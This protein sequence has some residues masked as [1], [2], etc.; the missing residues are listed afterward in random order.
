MKYF[1]S[2]AIALLLAVTHIAAQDKAS[3]WPQF[4][5]PTGQGISKDKGV[6]LKWGPKE[7]I[8]W[9]TELPGAGASSPIVFGQRIYLTAF[10]GKA[11]SIELHVLA[12]N[13]AD[14]KQVW[15]KKVAPKLP[16]Q[17]LNAMRENHGYASSTPC[18]DADG[19]YCFF[20]KT[21][22]IAF[23]HDGNERWRQSVGQGIGGFGSGASPV[24][25]E[26]LVIVN[27]GVEGKA[28]IALD[29]K[30]GKEV[31]RAPGN[32]DCSWNTPILV[33]QKNGKSEL[34]LAIQPKVISLDPGTGKQNWFSRTD[35][36]WYMVPRAVSDGDNVYVLG[37]RSG[38]SSLA[39]KLGGQGDVTKSHRFW[40]SNKGSNVSSPILHD[41]HL[42]WMNDSTGVAFCAV[43]ATGKTIYEERTSAGA[44][45]YAS[46]VL[47]EGR[48]Y[49]VTRNG[50]TIVLPAAPRYE[51]LATNDLGEP[52][53]QFNSSPAFAGGKIYLR[54]DRY[55]YCIGGK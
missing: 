48:I 53:I 17:P 14:G 15:V 33:P 47:A 38:V 13:R 1:A 10:T 35:I 43:A 2:S 40:T 23:D 34:I 28:I 30:S 36:G 4:R 31:W 42:Y 11:D 6:P 8:A 32:T 37:G 24:L 7:N 16:E 49:Y 12:F 27:A 54:T 25:Y 21:G 19:I 5:G 3:D 44:G 9:K 29:K 41:G 46:P 26:N 50:R 51:V 45:I 18:A 22:V 52:R 20:G 55:L 39:V